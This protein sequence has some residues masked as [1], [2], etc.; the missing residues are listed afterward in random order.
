M[1]L[2]RARALFSVLEE[3]DALVW[4]SYQDI[5][6]KG[7]SDPLTRER[8]FLA[9]KLSANPKKYS[10][11]MLSFDPIGNCYSEGTYL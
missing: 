4:L 5:L 11:L 7:R 2:F 9:S 8:P 3:A 1:F 10:S 6:G